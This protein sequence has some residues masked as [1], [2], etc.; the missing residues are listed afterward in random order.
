M[1]RVRVATTDA[2]NEALRDSMRSM[3]NAA[4]D[5]DFADEDWRHACG[6]LHVWIEDDGVPVCHASVVRRRFECAGRRLDVGYVEAV[7]TVASHRRRGLATTAMRRI[8]AEI[9]ARHE[10][11]ALSTGEHAFY[12]RLGWERWRGPTA[13][14][15]P[16]GRALTPDDDDA[17]MILRTPTTPAL[18]T[19]ASIVCDWRDGDVW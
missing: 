14:D 4:Y 8:A 12:A 7:A 5:G 17:I 15:A 6:G 16:E 11:G 1:N 19:T 2:L 3:L 9:A 10:L 13:V 18:D